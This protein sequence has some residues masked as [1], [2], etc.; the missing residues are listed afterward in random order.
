MRRGKAKKLKPF[1][2]RNITPTVK[3][4]GTVSKVGKKR[5]KTM[6]VKP[7]G[8]ESKAAKMEESLT[9]GRHVLEIE[10]QAVQSLIDRLD[11]KF[12]K[13]VDLLVQCKG[14]VVLSGMGKSG[15]I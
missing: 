7:S 15:H 4:A 1:A 9:D 13:A 8:R 12:A 6:T 11:A 10:A 5:S 14:K 3:T 2:R